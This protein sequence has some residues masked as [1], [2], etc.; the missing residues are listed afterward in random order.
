MRGYHGHED[1]T[2]NAL[3][4]EGRLRTGDLARRGRLGLVEFAERKKDVIKRRLL[5]VRAGVEGVLDEHPAVLECAV[6]GLPD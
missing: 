1:E 2:R 4:D 5:G 6:V 3:S